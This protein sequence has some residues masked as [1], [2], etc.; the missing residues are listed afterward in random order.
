MPPTP[1]PAA[2]PRAL[3][4]LTAAT[5]AVDAVSFLALDRVFTGNMTGNVVLLGFGL[6]GAYGLPVLQ[7]L[8]A[9]AAFAAG[10]ALTA[11]LLRPTR[12]S[13]TPDTTPRLPRAALLVLYAELCAAVALTALWPVLGDSPGGTTQALLTALLALMM[14]AQAAAV[15]PV[16]LPDLSTVVITST[17][18]TL[19]SPG[20][21]D[22]AP[23]QTGALVA[24]LGGAALG[25]LAVVHAHTAIAMAGVCAALAAALA[26]LHHA[27][28]T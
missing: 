18:V 5:G 9:L 6:V 13:G 21:R 4:L 24:M 23:R 26:V 10:A 27:R 1:T 2:Y 28:A 17:L 14:G 15:R 12:D 19:V 20:A 16:G 8:I 22:A 25:A 3:L 7:P 11:R